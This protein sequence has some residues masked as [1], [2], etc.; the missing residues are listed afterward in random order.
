MFSI[1]ND[2]VRTRIPIT[3]PLIDLRPPPLKPIHPA[4]KYESKEYHHQSKCKSRIQC[5]A[6]SHRVFRP[7]SRRSASYHIIEYV[8]YER[9]NREVETSSRRDPGQRAEEDREVD[10]ADDIAFTVACVEPEDYWCDSAD[11]EAVHQDVVCCV[12]P[13]KLAWPNDTPEYAAVE[14]YASERTGEA[15]DGFWCADLGDIGKHPIQDTDLSYGRDNCCHH[16]DQEE[17]SRWY[18]HVMAEL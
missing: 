14:V 5:S 1:R 16:L 18:L 17:Y 15:I 9:P 6:Q 4:R 12:G 7:P 2:L 13:E 11:G 3:P 10:L 8:T